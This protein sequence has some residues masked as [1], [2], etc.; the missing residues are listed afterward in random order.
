MNIGFFG[1]GSLILGTI[2]NLC[3]YGWAIPKPILSLMAI[4]YFIFGTALVTGF[5]R[6]GFGL[7][8][9][10]AERYATPAYIYW[11]SIM[12]VWLTLIPK[13]GWG[14]LFVRGVATVVVGLILMNI[15]TAAF[16]ASDRYRDQ[17]LARRQVASALLTR[18]KDPAPYF[19]VFATMPGMW[20]RG[21]ALR[22][23]QL[24]I[25]SENWL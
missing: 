16:T 6:L 3:R 17:G 11:V 14:V 25:F 15:F 21:Q 19:A 13:F 18:V 4:A 22:E 2:F 5:G 7:E 8:Q 20:A 12:G 9:A 1:I 24:S 23:S 10:Q